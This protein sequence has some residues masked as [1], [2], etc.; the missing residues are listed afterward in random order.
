MMSDTIEPKPV[1]DTY[2]EHY[3]HKHYFHKDCSTCFTT[4]RGKK[5]YPSYDVRNNQRTNEATFDYYERFNN[6]LE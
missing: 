4:N 3:K 1:V 5:E 6:P 2:K